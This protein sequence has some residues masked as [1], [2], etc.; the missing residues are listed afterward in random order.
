MPMSR[1][2]AR[3]IYRKGQEAVVEALMEFSA[4]IEKLEK[5]IEWLKSKLEETP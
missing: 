4:K 5:E 2:K 3:A 1:D